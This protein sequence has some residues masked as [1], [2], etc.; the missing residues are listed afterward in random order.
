MIRDEFLSTIES[1]LSA[2]GMNATLFGRLSM[3]DS[4]FVHRIRNGGDVRLSTMEKVQG[5]MREYKSP[6]DGAPT[7]EGVQPSPEPVQ[8][9]LKLQAAE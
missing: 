6:A 9:E 8:P 3:N 1:F 7:E 4:S 2:H 5:F